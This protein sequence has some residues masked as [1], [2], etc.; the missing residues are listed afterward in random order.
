MGFCVGDGALTTGTVEQAVSGLD[1]VVDHVGADAVL[2]L[3][4]TESDLR[5]VQAVVQ[6]HRWRRHDCWVSG[7]SNR[8]VQVKKTQIWGRVANQY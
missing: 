4:E 1:G 6:L 3:P 7:V 8:V 2:D 5:H